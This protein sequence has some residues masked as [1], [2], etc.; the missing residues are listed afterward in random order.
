MKIYIKNI[1]DYDEQFYQKHFTN[2][3]NYQNNAQNYNANNYQ[4]NVRKSSGAG[5]FFSETGNVFG[6]NV[7]NNVENQEQVSKQTNKPISQQ[8]TRLNNGL[9]DFSSLTDDE[10]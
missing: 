9:I 10:E 6:A 5:N 3:N 7:D 4:N 2:L 8:P 1:N